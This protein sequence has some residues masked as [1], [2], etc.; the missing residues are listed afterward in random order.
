MCVTER[1]KP[2]SLIEPVKSTFHFKI[3]S[4]KL[5]SYK[6][7]NLLLRDTHQI[8]VHIYTIILNTTARNAKSLKL[9]LY[10]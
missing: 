6:N 5:V 4:L 7:I 2:S 1:L 3:L 10:N 9:I 8:I